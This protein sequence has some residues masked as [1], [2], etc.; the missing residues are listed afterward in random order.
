MNDLEKLFAE[1]R[2][3]A[4]SQA[5]MESEVKRMN[6]DVQSLFK[7]IDNRFPTKDEFKKLE[8]N[9]QSLADENRTF[10]TKEELDK[11]KDDQEKEVEK[12]V[13]KEEFEPIKRLAYGAVSF[14]LLAVLGVV[15]TGTLQK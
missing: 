5:V 13:T 11:H 1:I 15:I 2:E 7:L 10:V 6:T 9:V 14:I 4:K 12:L 3:I 8:E